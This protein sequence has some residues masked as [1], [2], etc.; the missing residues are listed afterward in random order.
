MSS[1]FG[2]DLLL[3]LVELIAY[4]F[5]LGLSNEEQTILAAATK[6]FLA[7]GVLFLH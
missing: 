2:I 4:R 6:I 7:G 5:A 3:A 1:A